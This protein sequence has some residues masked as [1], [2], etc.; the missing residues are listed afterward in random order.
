MLSQES[1]D[2]RTEY[3]Y[4]QLV[5]LMK[6]AGKAALYGSSYNV[7]FVK[8][9]TWSRQTFVN[10]SPGDENAEYTGL[11]VGEVVDYGDGTR[12][13]ALGNFWPGRPGDSDYV[14]YEFWAFTFN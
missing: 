7:D 5:T 12:M 13:S 6:D 8:K 2:E 14:S 1:L 9:T 10:K 11:I 3:V 4:P